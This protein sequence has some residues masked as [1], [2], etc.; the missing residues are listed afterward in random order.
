MLMLQRSANQ[1][2]IATY[3]LLFKSEDPMKMFEKLDGKMKA[4]YS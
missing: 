1:S 3:V 4:L 2:L